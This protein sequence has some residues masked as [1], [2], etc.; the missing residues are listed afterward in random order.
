MHSIKDTVKQLIGKSLDAYNKKY[1]SPINNRIDNI[2]AQAGTD[3]TEIVD[4]RIDSAGVSHTTLNN[5]I[6][7]ETKMTDEKL[8][9]YSG[10]SLSVDDTMPGYLQ[11]IEIFGNTIQNED[12]LEDIRS[13][14]NKIEGQELYEIPV[15]SCGKNLIN[16][17]E[18]VINEGVST[19]TGNFGVDIT[20]S[21]TSYIKFNPNVNYVAINVEA[22]F[23]YDKNKQFISV[24]RTLK[25]VSPSNCNYIVV[26]MLNTTNNW[27][28]EEGTVATPYEPYVG[29]KLTILSPVQ[30]EK[31]GDV[32]DRII[33]KDGVWGVE[34]NVE[35]VVLDGNTVIN[36]INTTN[37][38]NINYV[39]ITIESMKTGKNLPIICNRFITESYVSSKD[40]EYVYTWS[41]DNKPCIYINFLK[42]KGS[43]INEFKQWLEA[44]NVLVKYQLATSTFIPL[45][46]D[47][48]VKLRTFANKTNISFLTEIE[49]TIKADVA[50][51]ISAS[52]NSNTQEIS[53]LW[54][55]VLKNNLA[56]FAVAL[57]ALDTKLRLE[58]LTKTPR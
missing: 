18:V 33:C 16:V 30:L 44:N 24:D 42:S 22:V 15:L 32:A 28:L 4:A 38:T 7:A 27:Q 13:V 29:D 3:N 37:F 25:G 11:N 5:R 58:Q 2:V 23:F 48:Q 10:S 19:S 21:R 47:Q 9:E 51:S 40:Y 6:L 43:T 50:K 26:R 54:D 57:N 52:V 8:I 41:W 53:D 36:N 20:R 39:G 56:N 46:H 31:V 55:F 1:T 14:G 35:T 17:N 12:N 45:P 49:G 34:K